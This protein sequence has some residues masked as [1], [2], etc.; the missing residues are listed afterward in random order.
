M[1]LD[2]QTLMLAFVAIAALALV[3]QTIGMLAM[4]LVARK[5]A[6]NVHEELEHYRSSLMPLILRSRDLIQNVAPNLEA[7]TGDMATITAKLR[8]QTEEIQT[9]TDAIVARAQTQAGRAD[10]MLTT[11]FDGVE[12]A[13]WFMSNTVA[14]PLRQLSGIVASVKAAVETLRDP[15]S[16]HP[17][18]HP[19]QGVSRYTGG[20]PEPA[21]TTGRPRGTP[22]RP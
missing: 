22:L 9:V 21:A 3:V 13:S 4:L 16:S 18:S 14:R 6:N 7:A 15:P 2:V 1:S 17:R 19:P 12:R 8:A 5:A 20:E 10:R 11:V